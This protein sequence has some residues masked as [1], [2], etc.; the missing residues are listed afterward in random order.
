[1]NTVGTPSSRRVLVA[2]RMAGWN[3]GGEAEADA[4]LGDGGR[5]PLGRQGDRDPEGLQQV[6]AAAAAGGGPVAVL[7]HPLAGAGGDSA[8][9]VETLKVPARSPP[10][11]QVSSSGPAPRGARPRPASP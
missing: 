6:G 2:W 10:V 9:R 1:L 7:G 3:T 4:H 5:D 8:A 11:P